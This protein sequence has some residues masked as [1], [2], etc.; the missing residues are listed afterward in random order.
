MPGSFEEFDDS[1]WDYGD[2]IFQDWKQ[3]LQTSDTYKSIAEATKEHSMAIAT[4]ILPPIKGAFN[5]V[6]RVDFVTGASSAF[7]L[8][9]PSYFDSGD[10]KIL[11]EV[12]TMRYIADKTSIPVPFVFHYGSKEKSPKKLGPFLIMEWIKHDCD[13][14]EVLN[15]PDIRS[16]FLNPS[17]EQEKLLHMYGQ[18]ADILL[19]LSL[20]EFTSIGSL[21]VELEDEGGPDVAT[22]PLSLNISQLGNFARVPP[23]Q[24][25]DRDKIFMSSTSYYSALADMHLQQLSFQRNQAVDS[26]DNCRKKY[27]ARQLFRKLARENRL[28]LEQFQSG[29]FKLWCDDLR[30][31]NVLVDS[32]HRIVGVIDWEFS[33]AAPAEFSFSPPWWLLLTPPDDWEAGLDDWATHYEQRLHT[34]LHVLEEKESDFIQ[35]GR[36]TATDLLSRRMRESWTSG[37]F[38]VTYAARR[39]WAFDAIYWKFIDER[40]FGKNPSGDLTERL[41]LLPT[42][43]VEAMEGFVARKMA[44]K[45]QQTLVDW[46][47]PGAELELPPDILNVGI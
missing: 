16:P 35:C 4:E 28:T 2:K 8:S 36:M 37:D 43:Q 5:V 23:S 29:P 22:R 9:I 32:E 14:C 26:A 19:Q 33:Y 34:F 7:R 45:E 44:E 25:P 13:M 6:Y 24:L 18:M 12:A 42:A 21:G 46:Y 1:A 40:F 31:T 11:A 47:V 20:C 38:W 15:A 10:E 30:P 17:I 27:I 3:A 41:A 39:T